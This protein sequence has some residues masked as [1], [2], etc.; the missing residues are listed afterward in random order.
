MLSLIIPAAKAAV[1]LINCPPSFEFWALQSN[2]DG[3][4]HL[5]DKAVWVV[6]GAGGKQ[7]Y[8]GTPNSGIT[9]PNLNYYLPSFTSI[10]DEITVSINFE[11]EPAAKRRLPS[12]EAN[13]RSEYLNSR[14]SRPS[15][16]T[17]SV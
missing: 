4:P 3:V 15:P 17:L 14:T 8:M 2:F 7:V 5:L 9:G 6:R 12:A 10:I 1:T 13:R 11:G 16:N